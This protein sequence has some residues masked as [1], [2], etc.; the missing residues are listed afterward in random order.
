M[1]TSRGCTT[2]ASAMDG[3]VI[4]MRV[5]SKSVCSTVDR[6]AVSDTRLTS[7]C[8]WAVRPIAPAD[9]RQMRTATTDRNTSAPLEIESSALLLPEL[10]FHALRR[11]NGLHDIVLLGGNDGGRPRLGRYNA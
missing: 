5:M 8:C 6:P 3:S 2:T 7:P 9:I 11:A 10:F 1:S 4:A